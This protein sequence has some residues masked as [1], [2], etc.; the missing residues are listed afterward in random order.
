MKT[1][2][3]PIIRSLTH[4]GKVRK[5]LDIR[6]VVWDQLHER[7]ESTPEND[8]ELIYFEQ[9]SVSKERDKKL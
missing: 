6:N 9:D 3:F 1:D 8:I 2:K 5:F 4:S 7:V